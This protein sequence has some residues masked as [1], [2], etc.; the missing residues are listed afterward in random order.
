ME[1]V[2]AQLIAFTAFAGSTPDPNPRH[3]MIWW[4]GDLPATPDT[5]PL[6]TTSN[7]ALFTHKEH[8]FLA[9]TKY[10]ERLVLAAA[11][12]TWAAEYLQKLCECQFAD[13]YAYLHVDAA[14]SYLPT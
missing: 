10:L 7:D 11:T 2:R 9:V 6:H 3:D 1:H 4:A 13:L 14:E 5:Y 12:H 8:L